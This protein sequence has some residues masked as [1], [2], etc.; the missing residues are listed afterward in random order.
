MKQVILK[1]I[2]DGYN[3]ETSPKHLYIWLQIFIGIK[4]VKIAT[5]FYT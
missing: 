4:K 3:F 5:N 1:G 2:V